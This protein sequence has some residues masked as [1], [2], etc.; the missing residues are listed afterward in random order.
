MRVSAIGSFRASLLLLG[1]FAPFTLSAPVEG[2]S[3]LLRTPVGDRL[4]SDIHAIPDGGHINHDGDV[5]QVIDAAGKVVHSAKHGGSSFRATNTSS[6]VPAEASGWVTYAS[7]YNTNKSPISSF[8][9]TWTVPPAPVS[10]N[11]QTVF[12]FNSIEPA[13]GNAIIQPVLQYGPS[14]AGGGKYWSIASW[15]LVGSKVYHTTLKKTSS[16]KKL[17][18]VIKLTSHS[19]S[20]YNYVSSFTGISGTS[21]TAKNSA[22]L[23]WATETLESYGVTKASH[24]PKGTTT[25]SAITLRLSSGTPSVK[26]GVANDAKDKLTTTVT[27][28]GATNAKIVVHYPTK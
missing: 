11:S 10:Y 25:F 22:Q 13:S 14:A 16:C 4:K 19:G 18:G 1:L 2:E 15:Y 8:T 23:V 7:W 12:L 27:T 3:D 20:N 9:T 26:W 24:Y 5:I 28:Q 6:A 17:T 21:L